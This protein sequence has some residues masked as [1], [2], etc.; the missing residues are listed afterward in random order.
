VTCP[1][2]VRHRRRAG[3]GP[4]RGARCPLVS[5]VA[6]LCANNA[7]GEQAQRTRA[8]GYIACAMRL[9]PVA[10]MTEP[11][12]LECLGADTFA[13]PLPAEIPA[14][15]EL[16]LQQPVHTP[17][18]PPK[19]AESA[20]QTAAIAQYT[21]RVQFYE[22]QRKMYAQD[23]MQIR[24]RQQMLRDE[25][26]V[27]EGERDRLAVQRDGLLAPCNPALVRTYQD[28]LIQ[29][30]RHPDNRAARDLIAS[31]PYKERE[32]ILGNILARQMAA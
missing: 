12:P 10:N 15:P 3:A 23:L 1:R 17:S 26:A 6:R 32:A 5:L 22:S 11:N 28:Q 30:L 4:A 14:T 16:L 2:V 19:P 27:L 21:Q 31:K 29:W 20:T 7:A 9:W 13:A 25:L 8:G 18:P 24:Q